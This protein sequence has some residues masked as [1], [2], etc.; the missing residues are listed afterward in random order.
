MFVPE[1]AQDLVVTNEDGFLVM[2]STLNWST[3]RQ[4]LALGM[5]CAVRSDTPGGLEI[6]IDFIDD[7]GDEDEDA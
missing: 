6:K 4:A 7:F 2:L 3:L 1:Q 5:S